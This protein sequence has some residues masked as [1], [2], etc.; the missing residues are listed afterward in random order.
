MGGGGAR[1][2][3]SDDA[4]ATWARVLDVGDPHNTTLGGLAYDPAQPDHVF[5]ATGHTP[6]PSI[7]GVQVS[8]DGGQTWAFLGRQDIGWINAL[9]RLPDGTLFGATNEGVWRLP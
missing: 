4:G 8:Q 6:D 5:A 1:V 3:R 7:T 2:Y 9:V